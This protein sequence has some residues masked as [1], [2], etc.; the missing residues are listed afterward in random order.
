MKKAILTAL[1]IASSF[2]MTACGNRN[3]LTSPGVPGTASMPTT[4]DPYG[5]G[6]GYLPT[7]GTSDPYGTGTGTYPTTGTDPYGT[8]TGAYPTTGTSPYGTTYPN[9]G[10]TYPNTGTGYPTT[11]SPYGAGTGQYVVD[12]MTGQ[13]MIDPMTGQP[14]VNNGLSQQL[15]T[16]IQAAGGYKGSK[17]DNTVVDFLKSNS[18]QQV[19][20]AAPL[21]DRALAIKSLLDG[22]CTADEKNYAQQIWNTILPQD[23]QTL[24]AQDTDLSKLV[25][26]KLLQGKSNGVGSILTE[27]GKMVGLG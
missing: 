3:S 20:G 6:S 21:T 13:P 11:T 5:T 12:P 19:F 2:S 10:T 7:T 18:V 24:L 26:S 17:A 1:V 16:K 25:T 22:W 23:Q 4:G 9:T 15:V 8:G 27:I 14:M